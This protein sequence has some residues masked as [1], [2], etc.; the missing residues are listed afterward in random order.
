MSIPEKAYT[1]RRKPCS[2]CGV[3]KR[4]YMNKIA[5]KESFDVIVTGHNLDDQAAALLGNVLYWKIDY[6][7]KGAYS[8]PS[9]RSI[10]QSKALGLLQKED[11]VYCLLKGIPYIQKECPILRAL[12]LCLGT[13]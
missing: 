2:A 11:A 1:K 7:A 5:R 13:Y 12:P 4:Y 3:T 8:R 9:K 10:W 6:L